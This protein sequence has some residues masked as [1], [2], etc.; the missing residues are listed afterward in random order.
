MLLVAVILI[1]MI[2]FVYGDS[3]KLDCPRDCWYDYNVASGRCDSPA[4]VLNGCDGTEDYSNC[5]C[6]CCFNQQLIN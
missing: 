4:A 6:W 1:A 2:R 5:K 3:H